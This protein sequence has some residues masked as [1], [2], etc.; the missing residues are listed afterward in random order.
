[1]QI[2]S[3][4]GY[5]LVAI[6]ILVTI[7]ELGHFWV[8]KKMGVKVLQFSLGFGKVLFS[9]KR[10]ETLYTLCAVP[11]GGFVKMLGQSEEKVSPNEIHRAFD[12]QSV[13]KRMAIVVAGP[14][15]NFLLAIFLYTIVF[16]LGIEGI[17]PIV[18]VVKQDSIAMQA[19]LKTGDEL[20]SVNQKLTPSIAEFSLQFIKNSSRSILP[21]QL[22][23][24]NGNLKN[25]KLKLQHDFLKNPEQGLEKY[26][27]FEFS[28]PNLKPIIKTVVP[29]SPAFNA[30]LKTGDL[31]ISVNQ[32]NI[33]TWHELVDY[34][35]KEPILMLKILRNQQELQISVNP[36]NNKLGV[37]VFVP[38]DFL[39]SWR[40]LIQKNFMDAFISANQHI[41][42]M[43]LVNL[44]M[45]KKMLVGDASIKHI[46]GPVSI[47][48]YAGKSANAGLVAFLSFMAMVSLGLGLL[49]ILPIPLLDGGHLAVY[50][51]EAIKGSKV[52]D[53][54]QASLAKIGFIIIIMLMIIALYNDLF[55]LFKF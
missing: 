42:Q 18:G 36:K 28:M 12:A 4:I 30:G 21:I 22:R 15:A 23:S 34:I 54:W 33:K 31:I 41:Y 3:S 13:Y 37:G 16:M 17:K 55:R 52:S 29:N 25:S 50:I 39:K 19:G 48:D 53:A 6:L 32:N 5:F 10:G 27:G 44:R 45:I 2:F 51:V 11:L 9:F 40:V 43:T 35:Q 20:L 7:H 26:L 49:N 1:M 14:L 47:A 46:S 24:S 38:K 8:A